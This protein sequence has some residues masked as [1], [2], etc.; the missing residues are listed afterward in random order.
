MSQGDPPKPRLVPLRDV[1]AAEDRRIYTSLYGASPDT[2]IT[3][4]KEELNAAIASDRRI[5]YESIGASSKVK[6]AKCRNLAT[7][8]GR[9][10]NHRA[11][12]ALLV[13]SALMFTL[14]VFVLVVCLH[15]C[16]KMNWNGALCGGF[17]AVG[18][19][20]GIMLGFVLYSFYE[21]ENP[22]N[23]QSK[24]EKAD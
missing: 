9:R 1:M 2:S 17:A 16:E 11:L 13:G 22:S 21:E 18:T 4:M 6:V 14:P 23:T 12:K 15:I 24:R 7:L 3:S 20:V 19:T 10:E 8:L 5:F